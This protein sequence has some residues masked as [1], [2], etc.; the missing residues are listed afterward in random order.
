MILRYI[1]S[2]FTFTFTYTNQTRD[3]KRFAISEVAADWRVLMIAQRLHAGM[4]RCQVA[5][6]AVDGCSVNRPAADG[7]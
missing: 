1:N 5:S 2:I 4:R 6:V 7:I 3:E